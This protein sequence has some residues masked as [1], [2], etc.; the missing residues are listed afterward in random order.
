MSVTLLGYRCYCLRQFRDSSRCAP[1]AHRTCPTASWYRNHQTTGFVIIFY[2]RFADFMLLAPAFLCN[3]DRSVLD[4]LWECHSHSFEDGS[5]SP[6]TPCWVHLWHSRQRRTNFNAQK[7]L[8]C[9]FH[10][11]PK[12]RL[13]S[14]LR[15]K[16]HLTKLNL[17]QSQLPSG[18]AIHSEARP[19]HSPF[20]GGLARFSPRINQ[21]LAPGCLQVLLFLR[22]TRPL[23][24][25][26]RW[27]SSRPNT[28]Y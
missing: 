16:R 14:Y 1:S 2:S 18:G 13:T 17:F 5:S 8:G 24:R 27:T 28:D 21:R 9:V 6:W 15:I 3:G 10:H 25:C 12:V 4:V 7:D 23:R 22:N 26:R 19:Y 20:F 11:Q